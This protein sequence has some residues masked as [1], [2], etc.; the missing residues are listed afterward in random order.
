MVVGLE[1]QAPEREQPR[2]LARLLV[3][4]RPFDRLARL[5]Q[6]ALVALVGVAHAARSQRPQRALRA[7]A[8]VDARRTEEDDGVLDLLF[9]ETPQRLEVLRQDADRARLLALE[10]LR[11]EVR[12]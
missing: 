4:A 6:L 10:K 2:E 12:H 7:L 1:R 11:I 9:P 8:A 5:R 3:V